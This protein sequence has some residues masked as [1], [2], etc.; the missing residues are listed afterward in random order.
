MW[1]HA[2]LLEESQIV[3]KVPIVGD[4]GVPHAQDVRRDEIHR[5]P[6]AYGLASSGRSLPHEG[7]PRPAPAPDSAH[8]S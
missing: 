6:T 2:N 3:L 4:A 7:S 1:H 5:L 8:G